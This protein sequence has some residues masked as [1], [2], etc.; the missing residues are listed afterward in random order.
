MLNYNLIIIS[1]LFPIRIIILQAYIYDTQFLDIQN[2]LS[3]DAAGCN[4]TSI[5][6]DFTICVKDDDH[7]HPFTFDTDCKVKNNSIR[8]EDEAN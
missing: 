4:L 1:I 7:R 3:L 5:Y 2:K 8:V 6:N